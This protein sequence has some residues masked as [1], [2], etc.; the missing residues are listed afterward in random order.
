MASGSNLIVI[1]GSTVELSSDLS[2]L[3]D[4]ALQLGTPEVDTNTGETFDYSFAGI[5]RAFL[6]ARDPV[7]RWFREYAEPRI[8]VRRLAESSKVDLQEA[9]RSVGRKARVKGM[10][11]FTASARKLF[12]EA[13]T[14]ARDVSESRIIDVH[15]L[16]AAYI[17]GKHGHRS[18]LEGWGFK[19]GE[20][21]DTFLSFLVSENSGYPNEATRW[22]KYHE[23]H[24]P[25]GEAASAV[26]ELKATGEISNPAGTVTEAPTP[27]PTPPPAPTGNRW[28][29]PGVLADS[30]T[31][32]DRLDITPDVDAFASVLCSRE[33][34]P[35]LSIG[36]FGDWGSGKSFFMNKMKE[37]VRR[38][39]AKAHR[40]RGADGRHAFYSDIVQIEFNAWHYVE[41]NLWASLVAHIFETLHAHFD[42]RGDAEKKRWEELVRQ[43]YVEQALR[44]EASKELTDAIRERAAAEA[45]LNSQVEELRKLRAGDVWEAVL[46][47]LRSGQN[48]ELVDE[49][50]NRIKGL[51]GAKRLADTDAA[52][53]SVITESRSLAGRA[54]IQWLALFRG[55]RKLRHLAYVLVALAASVGVTA[56]LTDFVETS[57]P[58]LR[59][60]IAFAGKVLSVAAAAIA[61]VAP[62]LKMASDTLDWLDGVRP[63][64][65]EEE[66]KKAEAVR[67]QRARVEVSKQK[68]EEQD[69]KISEIERELE[70]LRPSQRLAAFLRDRAESTDYR[71]HLGVLALVRR[72][73]EK[74]NELM[75]RQREERERPRFRLPAGAE[76]VLPKRDHRRHVVRPEDEAATPISP[77]LRSAFEAAGEPLGA[78]DALTHVPAP[79][80]SAGDGE[81]GAEH[82]V[83]R[84]P[85]RAGYVIRRDGEGFA[86]YLDSGIPYVD[87]VVLYI[88]DL[89]RCPPKHVVEVLQAVH[90]LLAL[91]IF[92][93]VVGVDARWVTQSLGSRYGELL[94][95]DGAAGKDGAGTGEAVPPQRTSTPAAVASPYDYLEKIFQ[96]PFW[97][98]PMSAEGRS[99]LVRGLL[100]PAASAAQHDV[101]TVDLPPE[102]P[103]QAR[104]QAGAG[105]VT[106]ASAGNGGAGPS[107]TGATP[108]DAASRRAASDDAKPADRRAADR[109]EL[110][111]KAERVKLEDAEVAAIEALRPILGRSPRAL[112]RFINIYRLIRA[113]VDSPEELRAWGDSQTSPGRYHA[114]L[115]LLAI[116]NTYPKVAPSLLRELGRTTFLPGHAS[117][118]APERRSLPELLRSLDVC[119]DDDCQRLCHVVE[120]YLQA[121]SPPPG[122]EDFI[123]IAPDVARYSYHFQAVRDQSPPPPAEGEPGVPTP[124][125]TPSQKQ[126]KRKK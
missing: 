55:E 84:R 70:S 20:W 47:G 103:P 61:W 7:S 24:R 83:V 28:F 73:F 8:D 6:V 46:A 101:P 119:R 111:L 36:L 100:A 58:L 38:I 59:Q 95:G 81:A 32:E 99:K 110:E 10:G 52:V 68:V 19:L 50:V 69:R 109:Q 26:A 53:R 116:V 64:V 44:K 104:A 13:E 120:V 27:P 112:K 98:R 121:R 63:K 33:L 77:R 96:I 54:R 29:L 105:E 65:T 2:Q 48:R 94:G 115:I 57:E 35:P 90:L 1:D 17:Y 117:R 39:S 118:P 21:A 11:N 25:P 88:D 16:M 9:V 91:P 14:I 15:H 3:M 62:R 106:A 76:Q 40:Q 93:V 56:L 34:E 51:I 79:A 66:N 22:Q 5:L 49:E 75:K 87:R 113:G 41:T 122:I 45:A 114:A 125:A 80:P 4:Q 18:Q 92:V 31:G 82:W 124:A 107:R 67:T 74:L 37:A 42:R 78:G 108:A 43:L 97:L 30:P 123:R 12:K 102:A 71:K 89:D 85:G 72:D 60:A 86:V 23:A 126:P